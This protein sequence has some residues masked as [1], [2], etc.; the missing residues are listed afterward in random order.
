[1]TCFGAEKVVRNGPLIES[2][3]APLFGLFD[4]RF[5]GALMAELCGGTFASKVDYGQ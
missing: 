3:G 5:T 1:M 4:C 2:A